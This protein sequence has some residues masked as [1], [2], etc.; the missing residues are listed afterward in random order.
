MIVSYV[1]YTKVLHTLLTI[2]SAMAWDT[3]DIPSPSNKLDV[4]AGLL[5]KLYM[6]HGNVYVPQFLCVG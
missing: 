1:G 3:Q 6:V 2:E 4:Y 5:C